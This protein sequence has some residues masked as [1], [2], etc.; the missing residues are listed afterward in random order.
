MPGSAGSFL[1]LVAEDTSLFC[2]WAAQVCPH[3]VPQ[4]PGQMLFPL[5]GAPWESLAPAVF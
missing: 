1:G 2:R 3:T 5:E 4:D